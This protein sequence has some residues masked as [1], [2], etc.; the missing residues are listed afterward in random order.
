MHDQHYIDIG[1]SYL[2]TL[3]RLYS[4]SRALALEPRARGATKHVARC[5]ARFSAMSAQMSATE[6]DKECVDDLIEQA[7]IYKTKGGYPDDCSANRKKSIRRKASQLILRK[8]EIYVDKKER[9][10]LVVRL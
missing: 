10:K 7:F 2:V 6:S 4:E 1:Y 8:G 9:G 3:S 5:S